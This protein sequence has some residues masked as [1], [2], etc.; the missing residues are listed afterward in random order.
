M[1]LLINPPSPFLVDQKVMPSLGIL[2]LSSTLRQAGHS[3]EILDLA[4][5]DDWEELVAS[6]VKEFEL[7]G[8]SIV[9]PQYPIALE[10]LRVIKGVNPN[11]WCVAGGPHV[12]AVGGVEAIVAGFDAAVVGEGERAILAIAEGCRDRLILEPYI[13]NLDEIPFPDR[14]T[15]GD[16][17][18]YIDGRRAATIMTA[19]GCAYG[20]CSFCCQVWKGIRFRSAANVI[21]ELKQIKE[22]G[23]TG[24][25]IYDDEFFA[26]PSRDKSIIRAL[27]DMDFYWRCFSRSDFLLRNEDLLAYAA[28]RGLREV[29]IGFESGSNK[30]LRAINKGV[31]REMNLWVA[32]LLHKY[33]IRCKAAMILG[34]P[35]ESEETLREMEEF[36]TRIQP[37]SVDFTIL[38]V[39]PSSDIWNNPDKYDLFWT[40][41]YVPYKTKP[42]EYHASVSTSS[43]TSARLEEERERLERKFN[44]A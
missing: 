3:V 44:P 43:L 14:S 30:I 31:T 10:I 1:M 37:E 21:A 33:G 35:S 8:V 29:L 41:A 32:Q 7:I 34:L 15:I 18:Y 25:Q 26:F 24:L 40:L 27:G 28:G 19:R 6:K 5:I 17:H 20:K 9:T 36:V 13:H 12:T 39:L 22:L 11:S 23:Y 4:G 16:Y 2:Y 42:H 38:S